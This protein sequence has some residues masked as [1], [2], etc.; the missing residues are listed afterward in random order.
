MVRHQ[1]IPALGREISLAEIG[2]AMD[3]EEARELGVSSQVA[4]NNVGTICIFFFLWICGFR[5]V[6]NK[7]SANFWLDGLLERLA[8]RE[9]GVPALR[10]QALEGTICYS[11]FDTVSVAYA[12]HSSNLPSPERM[13]SYWSQ[14]RTAHLR[15]AEW[16]TQMSSVSTA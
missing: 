8:E 3:R 1:F 14:Q 11:G 12:N 2:R 16:C 4:H 10:R 6:G 7:P 5:G 9:K 15:T 13:S